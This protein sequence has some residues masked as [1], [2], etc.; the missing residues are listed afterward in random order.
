M[1]ADLPQPEADDLPA[2]A[3]PAHAGDGEEAARTMIDETG[4]GADPLDG[5][6]EQGPEEEA[7]D[8]PSID[9]LEI[10]GRLSALLGTPAG[11]EVGDVR[12]QGQN[13]TG[14]GA[15]AIGAMH[16]TMAAA[17]E[18]RTWSE[19][20]SG[21][22]VRQA[23]DGYA[24]APSDQH[25]DRRLKRRGLLC[26]S[27]PEGT[28]RYTAAC[29]ASARRHGYD[30]VGL[31]NVESLGDLIRAAGILRTGH[32]YVLPLGDAAIRELDGMSLVGATARAEAMG[33]TVVL[34]G[35]FR[36]RGREFTDQIVEHRPPAAVDVFRAQLR[37]HLRGRCVGRCG[38][39]CVGACVDRYVE[40][41]AVGHPLMIAYLG[42]DPRPGEVVR[43]VESMARNAVNGVDL[44]P[45]LER[46]LPG[47]VRERAARILDCSDGHPS[48]SWATDD[49]RAFRLSCAVL[50][51][52]PVSEVQ[53][54]ARLLTFP[55]A[56]DGP[57]AGPPRRGSELDGLMGAELRQAVR[58]VD[59]DRVP[60][61]R[62]V[63]FTPANDA[64]RASLL[65]AAWQDWWHPERLLRWW[66]VLA[67]S[68]VPGV[69]HAAAGAIG[70]SASLAVR[71]ALQAV[72]ELARERRAGVRQTAAIA[73]VAMAMQP[74]LRHRLRTE[75]DRWAES[76]TAHRRDTVARAYALGLARLWPENALRHLRQVAEARMQRW[77]NSV[78]RGLV[79]VYDA[80]HAAEVTATLAGWAAS[81]HP[82][83]RLHAGRALRILADRW[84]P[85]P[86]DHWPELLD[87]TRRG[88]V[89]LQ[90]LATCWAAALAIPGTAF[91]AWRTLGFWLSR[92][93]GQAE[94]ATYCRQMLTA[95]VTD[96]EPL[97]RRL[98][99]QIRHVWQPMMPDNALLD[100][101]RRLTNEEQ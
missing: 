68:D 88:T 77:H 24:P 71:S 20:L 58:V 74:T 80:G 87:L 98:D 37:R 78:V 48:A 73:L 41:E 10:L 92:A 90:D 18:G 65:E 47:Q 12:V 55:A 70:W 7:E 35:D 8:D 25:L 96:R 16:V 33:C 21:T 56:D 66:V 64:L 40:D 34:V 30:R 91:R 4:T 23:A 43:V 83:V 15:T 31:I 42:G 11:I 69:R 63:E 1:I 59:D 32:G 44:T 84:S 5:P 45:R 13:A 9:P 100:D 85:V 57:L 101:L 26:L 19:T 17:G 62:R 82:E 76:G 81:D 29:L 2:S 75:L 79:E 97:R 51:G 49:R 22:T 86:R 60:G 6:E 46:L 99:H 95:V 50:A 36:S 67:R 89:Q 52:Q 27:G 61:G 53:R 14:T 72:D 28:G 93:D 54:A 39:E 38:N 3:P 94:V